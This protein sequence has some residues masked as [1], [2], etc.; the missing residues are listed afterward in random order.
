MMR[1]S[2]I[3]A[4]GHDLVVFVDQR[5]PQTYHHH[6]GHHSPCDRFTEQENA[7]DGRD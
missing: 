7:G 4:T 5:D 6:A 1:G 2:H 3:P